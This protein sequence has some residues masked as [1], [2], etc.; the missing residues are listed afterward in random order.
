[1]V[2]D[3]QHWREHRQKVKVV[4]LES[5]VSSWLG[6]AS[7]VA[8]PSEGLGPSRENI[9]EAGSFASCWPLEAPCGPV[10]LKR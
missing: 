10:P 3:G 8:A 9:G 4:S 7:V 5:G 1:M 2:D 6:V